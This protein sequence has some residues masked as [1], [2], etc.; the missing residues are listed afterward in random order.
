[1]K[2]QIK[3]VRLLLQTLSHLRLRQ[4]AY[5]LVR[6][7][8]KVKY[9]AMEAPAGSAPL[10]LVRPID[11]PVCV[12][13]EEFSFLNL[14]AQFS[15]WNDD[16]Y[17]SLWAYNLNYMD[18][19]GQ[20][21][22]SVEERLGWIERFMKD[23]PR[24]VIGRDPYPTALRTLN[25]V[26]F[27]SLYPDKQSVRYD[28]AL[29][30]QLRMLASN[31]EY[32]LLGNHLLEDAYALFVGSIY[33]ADAKLYNVAKTLLQKELEEQIL[34]D[35]AH[36]EQS[37]MYHC[38]LLD[39]LLD[40][41]NASSNNLRFP[42]QY[43][44]TAFL[45]AKAEAMLGHLNA[46]AYAD[47][48]IPLLND[49]AEDIAPKSNEIFAYAKR[50]GVMW[51]N[52]PMREVGYRKLHDENWEAIVDVGN[53]MAPYQCGHTHADTFTFEL[54][55]DGKPIVVDT[56]I[57]TYDKTPRRLYERGTLAHNTVSVDGR[58]SSEVWSGFRVG[59]RAKV[60]MLLD[61]ASR[62]AALHNGYKNIVHVRGFQVANGEFIVEDYLSN[63]A[64]GYNI[65]HFA[66]SQSVHVNEDM[67]IV[68]D[69]VT[70]HIQ[71]ADEIKLTK[72]MVSSKY[73]QLAEGSAAQIKFKGKMK[74]VF[75]INSAQNQRC[76]KRVNEFVERGYDV[77]TYAFSRGTE[78]RNKHNFDL[79]IIG[80]F[81]NDTSYLSRLN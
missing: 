1:M 21:N 39:R 73:N 76:I 60:Y 52:R 33:F 41:Y 38:I 51:H 67:S 36:F 55:K 10:S 54:R 3:K 50:L 66:P 81:A 25:W 19:L 28:N 79:Q 68:T 53:I 27:F 75:I 46:I 20:P 64:E 74:F 30:S 26:K 23:F 45:Q 49:S 59:K 58:N 43:E 44:I 16:G 40:A 29:Y 61:E 17:G 62:V 31:L 47:G 2:N 6:R 15:D 80:E 32:H 57:S 56:G 37:P 42:D 8:R 13:G 7:V 34:P 63:Q 22:L 9:V 11:K 14:S 71:G 4:I 78:M 5:Q 65:I 35:G 18:W 70:I 77:E 48:S 12:E 72:E 24:V 69:D